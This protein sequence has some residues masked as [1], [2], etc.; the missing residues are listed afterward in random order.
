MR[1][2]VCAR[3]GATTDTVGICPQCGAGLCMKHMEQAAQDGGPGG[4]RLSCQH[5]VSEANW[6]QT[7]RTGA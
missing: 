7:A 6:R 2:F 1:C 4:T 3:E 5:H